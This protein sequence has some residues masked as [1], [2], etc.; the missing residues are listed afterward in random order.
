MLLNVLSD[1]AEKSLA[2]GA[3]L[4]ALRKFLGCPRYKVLVAGCDNAFSGAGHRGQE[5][6]GCLGLR[7]NET[8]SDEIVSGLASRAEINLLP[9]VENG[10][11]VEQLK[12][13]MLVQFDPFHASLN[14][15][16]RPLGVLGKWLH[17][18]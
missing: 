16:H 7:A 8:H 14:L 5:V 17:M 12:G 18:R 1:L 9:F 11:F 3:F 10:D 2:L 13:K 15:P 6:G 4:P